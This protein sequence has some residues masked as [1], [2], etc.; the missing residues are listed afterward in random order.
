MDIFR[1]KG[2]EHFYI[3]SK[4]IKPL[5]SHILVGGFGL[6]I[7]LISTIIIFYFYQKN[8]CQIINFY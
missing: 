3:F 5:A 1:P 2:T 4:L 8:T 7:E 6:T